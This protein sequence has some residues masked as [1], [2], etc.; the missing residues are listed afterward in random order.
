MDLV[1]SGESEL[2]KLIRTRDWTG[3]PLGPVEQWSASL[4]TV[5]DLV[6]AARQ[7]MFISWGQSRILL[8]NDAYSVLLGERHPAA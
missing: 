4:R 1:T 8:Y 5:L 2:G 6:L 7:P 3:S